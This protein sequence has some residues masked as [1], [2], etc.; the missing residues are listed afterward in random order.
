MLH[1]LEV[2]TETSDMGHVVEIN[3]KYPLGV[4]DFSLY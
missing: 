3:E 2:C 1:F 4:S